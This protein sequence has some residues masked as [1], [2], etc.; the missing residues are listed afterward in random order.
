MNNKTMKTMLFAFTLSLAGASYVIANQNHAS[1][2]ASMGMGS[3]E[4]GHKGMMEHKGMMGMH[5]TTMNFSQLNLSESQEKEIQ[6][7]M[8]AAM[9]EKQL[10]MAEM[11]VQHADMQALLSAEVFD[12]NKASALMAKHHSQMQDKAMTMLKVKHQIFQVLD[13]EQKTQLMSMQN[14]KMNMQ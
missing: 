1:A 11:Q 3:M 14:N 10:D 13:D 4:M 9:G 12:E 8:A 7:I 6:A 5:N 2:G